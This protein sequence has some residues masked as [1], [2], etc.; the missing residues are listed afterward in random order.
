[1]KTP[2]SIMDETELTSAIVCN[3]RCYLVPSDVAKELETLRKHREE[4]L[5]ALKTLAE[6]SE[7]DGLEYCRVFTDPT[8]IDSYGVEAQIAVVRGLFLSIAGKAKS[9][10]AKATGG[11][12]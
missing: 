8:P 11:H 6:M 7:F 5:G 10:I 1:M 9:A 2:I 12:P 3:Q 4:L